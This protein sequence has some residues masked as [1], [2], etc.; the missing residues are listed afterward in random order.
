MKKITYLAVC[1]A[2]MFVACF[3]ASNI[4]AVSI[5]SDEFAAIRAQYT[6]LN[7]SA[8]MADYNIIEIIADELSD[9]NLRYAIGESQATPQNDLIVIRTTATQNKITLGGTELAINI[10]ASQR[11]S[12]TIISFGTNPLTIDADQQSRVFNIGSNANVALGG[13]INTNGNNSLG[14]GGILN[15]GTLV[16]MNCTVSESRTSGYSNSTGGGILNRGTLTA[17]DCT[18]TKNTSGEGGGGISNSGTLTVKGGTI[19][20]NATP[21]GRGGGLSNYGGYNAILT[22]SGVQIS[23]NTAHCGGGISSHSNNMATVTNSVISGNSTRDRIGSESQGGGIDGFRA[24]TV[25]GCEIVGNSASQGGGIYYSGD[26]GKNTYIMT[27]RDS[28]ITN[29][30]ATSSRSA[31]RGAGISNAGRMTIENSIIA[32]NIAAPLRDAAFGGGIHN[33]DVSISRSDSALTITNSVIAG[34]SAPTGGGI[35]SGYRDRDALSIIN[36]TIAGNSAVSNGGGI[37]YNDGTLTINNSIVAKNFVG[38]TSQDIHDIREGYGTIRGHN[39]LIGNRTGQFQLHAVDGNIV[40][41]GTNPI[42]PSFVNFADLTSWN[43][44][45]AANSPA[46]DK[47][48]NALSVGA[49]GNPLPHDLDGNPR[50]VNGTVD[51]GAYEFDGNA[52]Q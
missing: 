31:P 52:E 44:R 1:V 18:I 22:V 32:G 24:L 14:G 37:T 6:G 38:S 36:S 20:S 28:K 29:N 45:L 25:T 19:S 48:D 33:G 35:Y 26:S 30:A 40:G 4:L 3:Q 23:N 2:L 49:D 50:I 39:N 42:N 9:A 43:L 7:L 15:G 41:T 27:L 21:G 17:I 34:N 10:D 8:D 46:I 11:G 16:M 47:G 5:T 12:V 13:L 51:I